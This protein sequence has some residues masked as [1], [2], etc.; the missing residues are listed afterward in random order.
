MKPK[1]Q[2]ALD[3]M[4]KGGEKAVITSIGNLGAALKGRAGT[5]ITG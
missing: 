3:F 2:A 1:V 4:R 5:L